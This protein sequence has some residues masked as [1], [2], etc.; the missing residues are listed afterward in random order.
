M[1]RPM[2][3]LTT[4]NAIKEDL[5][6]LDVIAMTKSGEFLRLGSEIPWEEFS[7]TMSSAEQ[8]KLLLDLHDHALRLLND[9]RSESE[10]PVPPSKGTSRGT[11]LGRGTS[12]SHLPDAGGQDGS[13]SC[14]EIT[15]SWLEGWI[16]GDPGRRGSE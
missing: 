2:S 16:T 10:T 3:L 1:Q 12:R 11:P 8:A 6:F 9:T 4:L 15:E 7:K 13:L 5:I 14:A